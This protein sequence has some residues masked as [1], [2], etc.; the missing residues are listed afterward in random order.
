MHLIRLLPIFA[1]AGFVSAG[2]IYSVT[3]LGSLG[4]SS[5]V[6]FGLS[7]NGQ[8]VGAAST[9]F[10]FTHAFSSSGS[11][12]SDLTAGTDASEGLALSVNSAG[13]I[14]GTEFIGG[15]AYATLWQNGTAQAVGAAG[16]YGTAI[17]DAGQMA[18]MN[19]QGH[20]FITTDG[21][22]QDLDGTW[23]AAYGI[24]NGGQAAG[25]TETTAGIFRGFV[26]SP[27]TGYIVLGTLGGKSSYAMAI[28]DTGQIA[29]S[30]QLPSGYLH[31]FLENNG[32]LQDL[33]TLGG[34]SSYGYGINNAGDVVGYAALS[35]GDSH[36]FLFERGLMLDLN[37]LID[38][39]SGWVL[40]EAYAINGSGQIVGS[41]MLNGTQH[42]FRLDDQSG[43]VGDSSTG[44]SSS[45]PEPGT[46]IVML[47]GLLGLTIRW[48]QLHR[49]QPARQ[50]ARRRSIAWRR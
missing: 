1:I 20:A 44:I 48:L 22:E 41:G 3:D 50:P 16:S 5:A 30:A 32:T 43:S 31:A 12:M 13:Q 34:A 27:A 29:G 37:S 10:G 9:P 18:G 42:A 40:T 39:S 14:F 24:N 21:V 23:S 11:G 47:T 35:S 15:Q 17:N 8:V 33:G 49:R 46:W 38:P 26:W 25:Y 2:P 19:S 6:A 36:A 45:V 7:S 28:N 4:G